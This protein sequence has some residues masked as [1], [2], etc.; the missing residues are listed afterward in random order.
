MFVDDDCYADVFIIERVEQAIAASI[1]AIFIVLGDSD[2]L[3]RQDPISWD[4]LFEMAIAHFNK[5]LGLDINTRQMDVGPPQE[6]L[7]R[8]IT[9]LQAFHDH[10]KAFTV[11]EMTELVGL[12]GYIAASSRW[13]RHLLSHLYTSITSALHINQAHLIS[14]SKK[15]R[16][17]IKVARASDTLSTQEPPSEA[18]HFAQS[19]VARSVHRAHKRHFLNKTAKAEL[20]LILRALS[21]DAISKRCP[22][23]HLVDRVE[24][25]KA[26]GDSSL[27]AAG[28][29][30]IECKFWWYHEWS[31]EIR[32]HTLKVMRSN[33]EGKL[34]SI[35]ALEFATVIIS[36]AAISLF[37]KENVDSSNPFPTALIYADNTSAES[38]AIKG[39]KRSPMG[40]A[41]G[42]LLCALLINNPVGLSTDRVSTHDNVIADQI[43]R[44]KKE[45]DSLKFFA[46]LVSS[47]PQLRT[48]RRFIPNPELISAISDALLQ[49][50]NADPL[51]LNRLILQNPGKF[52]T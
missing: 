41:L 7:Q 44:L 12:L 15:F 30:S 1:E 39:C 14:S 46:S 42:R 45:R 31:A 52:T 8:T 23:A 28:G 29:F 5:I 50:T 47:H 21:D 33:K 26:H 19:W 32:A 51:V 40:R 2:L 11:A 37:F 49:G 22:I 18:K 36:Y 10:R 3:S 6:F 4:K 16:A 17:A 34:I 9:K 27:D 35:N 13:L 24:D 25:C 48:C 38:W 20:Q 43:S